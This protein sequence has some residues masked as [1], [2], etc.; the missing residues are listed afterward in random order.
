MIKTTVIIPNYNGMEY[1]DGCLESVF[2]SDRAVEVIVVDNGSTDGSDE[3]VTKKY[4]KVKLIKFVSNRGFSAAVNAGIKAA[5]TPYIFLLNDDTVIDKDTIGILEHDLDANP[6]IFSV[7][8]KM[9]KMTCPD[10]VD[11]AGDYYCALGWAYGKGKDKPSSDYTGCRNI[12]SAC[13]GAALYRRSVF[14]EIGLF[15][16]NHFAYLEDVDI[17]YRALIHGYLC[18]ADMN[19]IVLHAGSGTSGSRYNEFKVNLSS[20]NSVYLIYKNMPILQIILNLPLFIAGFGIKTIFFARKGLGRVYLRGV[21][22]GV[23][24]CMHGKMKNEKV[25]YDS[26]RLPT[27]IAIQILL[28]VNIVRFFL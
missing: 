1:I 15:D 19:A 25:K 6:K 22:R 21:M 26:K 12:F 20:R 13:A 9:L 18:Y 3:L 8:A 27:Y 4:P 10:L 14:K 7:Q 24:N 16:E 17:G 5:T 2:K 28:W 23:R 11:S